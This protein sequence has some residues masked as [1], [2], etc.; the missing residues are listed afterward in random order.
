MQASEGVIKPGDLK[1]PRAMM[2]RSRRQMYH[3]LSY[4]L[5]LVQQGGDVQVTHSSDNHDGACG[6]HTST[7]SSSRPDTTL[8]GRGIPDTPDRPVLNISN[9]LIY[10]DVVDILLTVFHNSHYQVCHSHRS[11]FILNP[12]TL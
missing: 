9:V 6:S 10:E 8:H 11:I 3:L 5:D 4:V 1:F 2:D 7:V 12:M